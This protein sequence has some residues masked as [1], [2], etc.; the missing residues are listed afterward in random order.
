MDEIK[1]HP[2][3]IAILAVLALA[4]FVLVPVVDWQDEMAADIS[5]QQKRLSKTNAL[6]ENYPDNKEKIKTANNVINLVQQQYFPNQLENVFKLEQQS[7]L[8]KIIEDSQLDLQ[9]L[10]WGRTK[11]FENTNN[12]AYQVDVRL[13]GKTRAFID[14]HN[15][16]EKQGLKI[17][18]DEFRLNVKR[19]SE[20]SVGNFQGTLKLSFYMI[21]GDLE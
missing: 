21:A 5:L 6:L 8:E 15:I 11:V 9:S 3:L 7:W 2:Y 13:R 16:I 14:L 4:N 17:S 20:S 12:S 10:G 1:Q 19:T 18:I